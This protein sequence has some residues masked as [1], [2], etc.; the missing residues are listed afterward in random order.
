MVEESG[1]HA[2]Q[3]PNQ[4]LHSRAAHC[5]GGSAFVDGNSPLTEAISLHFNRVLRFWRGEDQTLE[6]LRW[7]PGLPFLCFAADRRTYSR[8]DALRGARFFGR[9]SQERDCKLL[10]IGFPFEVFQIVFFGFLWD[11]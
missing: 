5:Y 6:Q 2:A 10:P 8:E 1:K 3:T 11:F 4:Q 9:G 7:F